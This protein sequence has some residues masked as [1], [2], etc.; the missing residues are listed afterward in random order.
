VSRSGQAPVSPSARQPRGHG[1]VRRRRRRRRHR[2]GLWWP[3]LLVPVVVAAI[4]VTV[5]EHPAKPSAVTVTE[6]GHRL[7]GVRASWDLLSRGPREVCL[8]E[9]ARGRITGAM[10]PAVRSDGPVSFVAGSAGHPPTVNCASSRG[11]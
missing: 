5:V 2:P 11:P 1:A 3:S 7:L 10:V 6:V 8:I 9:L 4:V